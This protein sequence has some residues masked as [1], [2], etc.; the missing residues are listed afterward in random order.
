MEYNERVIKEG[1]DQI[2]EIAMARDYL[3]SRLRQALLDDDVDK[4]KEY[5]LKICGLN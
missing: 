1:I 5:A 2:L 3:L 4:I